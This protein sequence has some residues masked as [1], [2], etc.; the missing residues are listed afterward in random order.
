MLQQEVVAGGWYNPAGKGRQVVRAPGWGTAPI[1]IFQVCPGQPLRPNKALSTHTG[2]CSLW[3]AE[4]MTGIHMQ[5]SARAETGECTDT[6][7]R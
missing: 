1:P 2:L 4:T 7:L 6:A 3:K 5:N